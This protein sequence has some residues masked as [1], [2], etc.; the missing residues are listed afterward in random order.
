MPNQPPPESVTESGHLKF[1]G[2]KK[3]SMTFA[4]LSFL[5]PKELARV[6]AIKKLRRERLQA[7]A[8]RDA[9]VQG[10][11]TQPV[12][13]ESAPDQGP[14][15]ANNEQAPAAGVNAVAT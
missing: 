15:A 10:E 13:A 11:V 6:E 2:T 1:S 9:A 8:A 7:Q 12:T 4:F 5:L 3:W 14:A